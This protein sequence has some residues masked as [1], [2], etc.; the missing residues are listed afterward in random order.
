[1]TGA[2]AQSYYI[3]PLASQGIPKSL[4]P[5]QTA[6]QLKALGAD[7]ALLESAV[8]AALFAGRPHLG[9]GNPRPRTC[10]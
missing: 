1:M 7:P 2:P 3:E 5:A 9:A 8:L 4:T 10:R 6:A